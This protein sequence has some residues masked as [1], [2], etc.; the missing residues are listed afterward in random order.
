MENTGNNA[1]K[2]RAKLFL[3][4]LN[5]M[6]ENWQKK[7]R[8]VSFSGG[9]N[10]ANEYYNVEI[11][12]IAALFSEKNSTDILE[13]LDLANKSN[14]PLQ[15]KLPSKPFIYFA[16]KFNDISNGIKD[17]N[18][19]SIIEKFGL[20]FAECALRLFSAYLCIQFDIIGISIMSFVKA[21]EKEMVDEFTDLDLTLKNTPAIVSK[22]FK[23]LFIGIIIGTCKGIV[24]IAHEGVNASINIINVP[25][26]ILGRPIAAAFA[27]MEHS[28]RA[29]VR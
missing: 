29:L 10:S 27:A 20:Y 7:G 1:N 16:H 28:D 12:A 18:F 3:E 26:T 21:I 19:V 9:S 2:G 13:D 8:F 23:A 5:T 22:F 4:F 15:S 11:E 6:W 14:D 25:L 24:A 17:K